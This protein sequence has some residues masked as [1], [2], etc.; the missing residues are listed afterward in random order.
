ME[1]FSYDIDNKT[2]E[3]KNFLQYEKNADEE[4]DS[5]KKNERE[6]QEFIF[7]FPA[8]FP[9]SEISGN[10]TSIWIP[11]AQEMELDTG[12]LDI[13]ATDGVGNIYIIECKLNSNHEMKTIRSQLDNYAAGI[14][15]KIKNL[16]LNDFWIWF[17]EEIKK[18]SKN[19]QTLE[20]II[21]EKIGKDDVESVLK[22]M[23]NNFN[24]N[25]N[26]LVFAVDKITSNLR[27]SIDWW[28]NSVDTSTNYPTF[29]LEVRQYDADKSNNNVD[30]SVQTYPF[31]LEKIKMKIESKSGK[32]KIHE[33]DEKTWTRNFEQNEFDHNQKKEIIKFT[34]D[35]IELVKVKDKG[36]LN[37]GTGG[38]GGR[39]M[40]RFR[41]YS[42]RSP[43]GLKTNGKLIIQFDLIQG[44]ERGPN[45]G[46]K[47]ESELSKIEEINASFK[48]KSGGGSNKEPGL[49]PETWLP[50]KD[51]IL[52]ILEEIF[53]KD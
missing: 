42:D 14:S 17:C 36:V 29:A 52:S 28:N 8:L 22:S 2:L 12:R 31:N 33:N 39:M 24:E 41:R 38:E 49:N 37:F 7:D 44:C 45:A 26:I 11:L 48:N 47:F 46:N 53:M 13:F 51:K 16:G 20:K 30:V 27:V 35:L 15:D 18:N 40:P 50:Y 4:K 1:I 43:I 10:E 21:E 32:R 6:L 23:K 5:K 3:S 34:E 9:V 19:H 25:R